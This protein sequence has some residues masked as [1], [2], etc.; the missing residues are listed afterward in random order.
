MAQLR[1]IMTLETDN[2]KK[3]AGILSHHADYILDFDSNSDIMTSIANVQSYEIGQKYDK[4]KLQMLA[5][6]IDDIL[7]DG[8]FPDAEAFDNT[9]A[10]AMYRTIEALQQYLSENI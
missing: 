1:V 5:D 3:L 2:P 7:P 10:Y 8:E 6:I 9:D 4:P